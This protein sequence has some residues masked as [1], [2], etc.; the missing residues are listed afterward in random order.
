MGTFFVIFFFYRTKQ[1]LNN[2][3]IEKGKILAEDLAYNATFGVSIEDPEIL[4]ILINGT[5][6]RGDIAYVVIYDKHGMEMAFKDP[7]YIRKMIGPLHVKNVPSISLVTLGDENSI[8][9]IV[10]PITKKKTFS[11]GDK[12]TKNLSNK[13]IIGLARLGVS[14]SSLKSELR[15]ILFFSIIATGFIILASIIIGSMFVKMIIT[16]ILNMARVATSIAEGDFTHSFKIESNDEIGILGRA[17]NKMVGNLKD[18]IQSIQKASANVVSAS[19]KIGLCSN[20]VNEGAQRQSKSIQEI[21]TSI[22][23]INSSLHEAANSID[24]LSN[25]VVATSSSILEMESSINEVA[26]HTRTLDTSVEETSSAIIELS[27]SIKEIA[28]HADVLSKAAEK[29]AVI[30]QEMNISIVK[31]ED[32]A[33]ESLRISEKV[34]DDAAGIGLESV[35]KTMESINGIKDNIHRL[36]KVIDGLGARSQQV[37]GILTIIDEVTDQTGLLALNAAILAAQSGEHGRGFAVVAEEIKELAEKTDHSTKEIAHIIN[38]VQSE[39]A[40]A[41]KLTREVLMNVEEGSKLSVESEVV[42]KK[43]IE[44]AERAKE[45]SRTINE[46]TMEGVENIKEVTESI[47]RINTMISQIAHATQ[48]QDEGIQRIIEATEQVRNISKLVRS[49]TSEQAEG[50][51]HIAEAMTNVSSKVQEIVIASNEQAKSSQEIL[52]AI[53]NIKSITQSNLEIASDM[54][55]AVNLIASESELLETQIKKFKI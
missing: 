19:H 7:L 6:E 15:K 9:D 42:L 43:I 4:G 18:M 13:D 28:D 51:G 16:P 47:N 30:A 5:F 10:V 25:T 1:Q 35:Q 26:N 37:G 20:S 34:S 17:F 54:V 38:A 27:A 33:K 46:M 55:I 40:E 39:V 48:E 36:A 22:E 12:N 8:Y 29:T 45:M 24:V 31:I 11:M 21:S 2:K 3:L 52:K 50:S 44:R 32:N 23:N 49:A 14:L 53:E 41:V